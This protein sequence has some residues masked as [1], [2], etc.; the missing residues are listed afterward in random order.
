MEMKCKLLYRLG[1]SGWYP[2]QIGLDGV[3]IG[4]RAV[5]QQVG[6]ERGTHQAF[7]RKLCFIDATCMTWRKQFCP[8]TEALN[9]NYNLRKAIFY[10]LRGEYKP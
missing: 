3:Y 5:Q 4:P 1:F 7:V 6:R 8:N 10:L 9:L 2:D